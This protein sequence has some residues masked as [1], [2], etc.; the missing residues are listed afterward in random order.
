MVFKMHTGK[1]AF[2]TLYKVM[3]P[4]K[5]ADFPFEK[6]SKTRWLVCGKV[7]YRI[8]TNWEELKAYFMVAKPESTHA[9]YTI[10]SPNPAGHVERLDPYFILWFIWRKSSL[11]FFA[12]IW[13]FFNGIWP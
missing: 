1:E 6:C 13:S 3:N 4:D 12:R 8:L 10:Q 11:A 2:R 7:D 5:N 9:E